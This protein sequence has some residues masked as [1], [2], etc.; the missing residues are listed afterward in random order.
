[1]FVYSTWPEALEMN[2]ELYISGSEIVIGVVH[3]A[4]L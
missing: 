3:N 1:M 4:L 2:H